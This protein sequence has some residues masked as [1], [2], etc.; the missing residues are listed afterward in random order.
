MDDSYKGPTVS[1]PN[2]L[3]LPPPSAIR[4]TKW[5]KFFIGLA[6]YVSSASKD[7]STKVGAVI[8]DDDRR[9]V[10]IGFNG[11]PKGVEDLKSRYDER[12]LKYKFIVHAERNALLFANK[13]TKGCTIYT[14]PFMPCSACAGMI[15]QAG[16]KHVISFYKQESRWLEDFKISSLMFKEAQV[17]LT[18]YEDLGFEYFKTGYRE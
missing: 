13:S 15:I 8:V 18:L 5:D 16:I 4:D 10:S 17:K 2:E 9:I 7:P 14:F 6:E 1:K 11:F 3:P 12:E